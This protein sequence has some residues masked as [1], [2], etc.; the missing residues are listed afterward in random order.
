MRSKKTEVSKRQYSSKAKSFN[1][2]YFAP[3]IGTVL[4]VNLVDIYSSTKFSTRTATAAV[5]NLVV[6]QRCV[7]LYLYLF[8]CRSP[9][10]T[11]LTY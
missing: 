7:H 4:A 3:L 11:L 9:T 8:W 5:L 6:V 2:H 1:V 10:Y